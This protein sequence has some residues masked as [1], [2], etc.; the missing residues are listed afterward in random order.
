MLIVDGFA[1]GGG[2]STGIEW[3]S[4]HAPTIAIDHDPEAIAMH[5]IN[6]P[7]TRHYCESIYKVRPEV[8]TDGA[9]PD[10]A[11][12][13]P[14]C[15]HFSQAKGAKPVCSKRRGLA[16]MV[17]AWAQRVRPRM[18]AVENVPAVGSYQ[19]PRTLACVKF[20]MFTVTFTEG[21]QIIAN[22]PSDAN[23]GQTRPVV[24]LV[25]SDD[26][27]RLESVFGTSLCH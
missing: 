11:W 14:D 1:G 8:A 9:S 19:R 2:A 5:A 3:G 22:D 24:P 20:A 15:T 26:V 7:A 18:I 12:F 10:F 16:W 21:V 6:H 27:T 4:G 13:S 17:T 25:P 23:A